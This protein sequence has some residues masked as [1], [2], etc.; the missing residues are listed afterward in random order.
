MAAF[1]DVRVFDAR[2]DFAGLAFF[3]DFLVDFLADCFVLPFLAGL[4][5]FAGAF[6]TLFAADFVAIFATN[7]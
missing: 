5:D 4:V 3:A 7:S 1:F 2:E 6:L